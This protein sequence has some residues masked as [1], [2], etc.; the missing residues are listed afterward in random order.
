MSF[1]DTAQAIVA[2]TVRPEIDRYVPAVHQAP[3]AVF[4]D[5]VYTPPLGRPRS[6]N[7][8]DVPQL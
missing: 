1:I 5:T 6:E 7:S 8:T 2:L 3:A 4:I